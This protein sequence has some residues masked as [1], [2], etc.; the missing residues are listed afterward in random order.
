MFAAPAAATHQSETAP[1]ASHTRML[2]CLFIV[3]SHL[4][5]VAREVRTPQKRP[6]RRPVMRGA[7][8]NHANE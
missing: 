8:E 1:I 6:G 2:D 5:E 4:V 7:P 3:V